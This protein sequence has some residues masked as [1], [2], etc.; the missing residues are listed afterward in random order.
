MSNRFERTID[1]RIDTARE[2][3]RIGWVSTVSGSRL[4]VITS[5]GATL[6]VPRL[7]SCAAT[8]GDVVLLAVTPAGWIAVG[9]IQP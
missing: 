2:T 3:H 8:G 4:V 6:T 7:A 1:E 9:K 5:G